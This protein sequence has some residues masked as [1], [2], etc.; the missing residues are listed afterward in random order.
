MN[1][2]L[3]R[4]RVIR[5]NS[6]TTSSEVFADETVIID[7]ERGTYFSLRGCASA[8][9][10]LLQSPTSIGEIVEAA[11]GA[12]SRKPPDDLEPVLAAFIAQL[13][14]HDLVRESTETPATP[15]VTEEILLNLAEPPSLEVYSDLAE[16]IAMDPVHEIDALTGWPNLPPRNPQDS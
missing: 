3:N 10:S 15:I 5:A 7:F 4:D 11:R 1:S 6:A 8:I 16:L 13:V 14:E 12:L 2:I 9:W